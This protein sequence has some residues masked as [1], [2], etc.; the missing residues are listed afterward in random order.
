ML[1]FIEE[2][3]KFGKKFKVGRDYFYQ[4]Y[5]AWC[6]ENGQR[7]KGKI[8]MFEELRNLF[9]MIKDDRHGGNYFI[10]IRLNEEEAEF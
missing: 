3:T 2:K 9:P 6:H 10:G 1:Y 5:V 8:N 7:P 4:A